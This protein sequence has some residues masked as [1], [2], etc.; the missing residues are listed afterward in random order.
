VAGIYGRQEPLSFTSSLDKRDLAIT[1]GLDKKIQHKDP[2]FH[3]ANSCLT[4]AIWEKFPFDEDCTN[5]EDR[6]WGQKVI[7]EGYKIV[8]EPD[9][10]VFHHHGIHH[11]SDERRANNIVRIM[12]TMADKKIKKSKVS[13]LNIAAFIPIRG[14]LISYGD[15][16]LLKNT[17][18]QLKGIDLI[19]DIVISTDSQKTAD[20]AK[21][22]GASRIISRPSQLSKKYVGVADVI[23][24]TLEEY[25]K[26]YQNLDLIVFMEETYPFRNKDEIRD[27]IE[28]L[29]EQGNDSLIAVK[30]EQKGVWERADNTVKPIIEQTFMPRVLK[31]S[32]IDI[33]QIGYCTLLSP[34]H[35]RFGDILG[36]DTGLFRLNNNL[37]TV[38]IRDAHDMSLY[39][40]ILS[41]F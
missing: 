23:K 36:P 40:D 26:H 12:D 25:E 29:I 31:S 15:K 24:F 39:V 32:S 28:T 34:Q 22:L 27:M 41:K 16:Y 20:I 18:T 11:G 19:N 38:E 7:K 8:Y 13:S 14:D 3:N 30:N 1:F 37:N 9:A 4:R 17:I 33:A 10:S 5:I 35:V 6:I 2:F 21:K